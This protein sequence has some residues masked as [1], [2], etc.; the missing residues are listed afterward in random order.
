MSVVEY[1]SDLIRFD[2]VS[3]K[4]NKPIADY[5]ESF[6]KTRN[7][8]VER[9]EYEHDGTLKVNVIGRYGHGTGG[10][11]YFGHTDVVPADDWSL[12]ANGPFS[13]FV[14]QGKLFGRGSTDMKGSIACMLSA[15]DETDPQSLAQPLYVS[16]SADEEIGHLG[17][18]K[19]AEQS[20]L[21][22]ELKTGNAFGIVGE[23]T[24]MQVIFA[25]KGGIVMSITSKGLAA[26]SSSHD[27]VNANL[28]MIPFLQDMKALHDETQT[29]DKW[30]DDRF[31]PST[32]CMNIGINDHT[33]AV[34]IKAAQS[35]CTI[36][37]RPMPSTQYDELVSRI[38]ASA[39]KHDLLFETPFHNPPFARDPKSESIAQCIQTVGGTPGTV[40]FGS[41]AC[42]LDAVKDLV[43]LGPGDIAQA[44]KS[45]EWISLQQLQQG[46]TS[47]RDLIT[48]FCQNP[49]Q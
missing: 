32:V 21:F 6:L 26:H 3:S 24:N 18:I 31:D 23:P 33:H 36:C 17:I 29:N 47:Y 5:L 38:R 8:E 14:S 42:N 28:K 39:K 46:Q 37:I 43:V 7:F 44:H 35:V 13:P 2:S 41:E 12:S 11:A 20:K 15:I 9:L 34:N 45:D 30:K 49:L 19:V 10:L 27:G 40:G 48:K 1:A 22:A 16:F 4:S 25:H